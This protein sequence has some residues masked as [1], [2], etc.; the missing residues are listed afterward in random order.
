MAS[1]KTLLHN[2]FFYGTLMHPRILTRVI[3]NTGSHLRFCPAILLNHTR[4]KIRRADYP[5]VVP[6]S[7]GKI[8]FDRELSREEKSVRGTLVTGL[9]E[10]DVYLLDCF[11][12]PEYD[13]VSV[14]V[15]P[16]NDLED[17]SLEGHPLSSADV[18]STFIPSN[19]PPLPE[20]SELSLPVQANTYVFKHVGK[21][22]PE[23]WPFH[24][25]VAKNA[26][27]WYRSDWDESE[28][29]EQ[30]EELWAGSDVKGSI[31]ERRMAVMV[32]SAP[33]ST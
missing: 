30:T 27:K 20:S 9:T 12:G 7:A 28:V 14:D 23:L 31:I 13:R 25:F 32:T 8:L 4:H 17:F 1:E 29:A 18:Q 5:G 2:A 22:E 16:L 33:V 26:H 21:L 10:S 19:P 11:E 6:Y 3:G 24:D 15:H